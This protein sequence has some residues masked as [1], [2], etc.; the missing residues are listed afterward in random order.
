MSAFHHHRHLHQ[1]IIYYFL[2]PPPPPSSY[3]AKRTIPFH[4]TKLCMNREV[5]ESYD[6]YS[7][8]YTNKLSSASGKPVCRY[9]LG[10]AARSVQPQS[11]PSTYRDLI[12]HLEHFDSNDLTTTTT[13][14][15][16]APFY[17]YYNPHRYPAFLSG[18]RDVFDKNDGDGSTPQQK[19]W[20]RRD[21]FI[22]SG[23]TDRTP[24]GLDQRL[25]D[26]L[27][28]SGGKYLDAFVLEYVCPD[29]LTHD[30]QQLGSE[31]EHAIEHVHKMKEMG[32]VRYVMASTHSHVVGSIL[33]SSTTTTAE[34]CSSEGTS[35]VPAL[36]ALMLRY[37]M[38][39]RSAAECLSLP[40]AL[41]NG[42]PVVAF[43]TTRWNRLQEVSADIP[44][45][46]L[47][48]IRPTTAD[49]IKFALNHPS[50]EIVLH[51]ARDDEELME[52]MLPIISKSSQSSASV[53]KMTDWLSEDELRLWRAYGNDEV[54]WNAG[55][56]FDEYPDEIAL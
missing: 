47:S 16:A 41:E 37:N 22:A 24:L 11:L 53:E 17:F 36:D 28:H 9:A 29:E 35:T 26:A 19:V 43:T 33:V 2:S 15:T 10:G 52:A 40:A 23:G 46:H 12:S 5:I 25:E 21:I 39:H 8:Y 51:S 45:G 42:I 1:C 13:T 3:L 14:S 6:P 31:L 50:V 49:C 55:D 30:N 48:Q 20:D 7:M 27:V 54:A 38:A 56:G 32:K 34:R 44:S 18:V 4:T